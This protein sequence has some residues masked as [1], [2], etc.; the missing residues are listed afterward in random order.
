MKKISYNESEFKKLFPVTDNADLSE[1]YKVAESTIRLWGA[2][3]K[4]NKKMWLWSRNDE[5]Y[6]LKHYGKDHSIADI[7]K[8]LGRSRWG[9]INKFREISNKRKKKSSRRKKTSGSG[10]D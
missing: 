10:K 6:I 5:N 7:A 8:M 4:L 9:V 3:L 1:K 2:K